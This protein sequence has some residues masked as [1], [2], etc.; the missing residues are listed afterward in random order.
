MPIRTYVFEHFNTCRHGA[1]N[2]IP[3]VTRI[4][5]LELF[6]VFCR[7]IQMKRQSF[8][9]DKTISASMDVIQ[10]LFEAK[11]TKQNKAELSRL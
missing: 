3:C 4:N 6:W 5:Y 1:K 2:D 7:N 11:K 10:Q 9:R 8:Q